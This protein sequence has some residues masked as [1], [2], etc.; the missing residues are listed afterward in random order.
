MNQKIKILIA[1]DHAVVRAGLTTLLGTEDDIEVV[2]QAKNGNE[3][4]S[5]T[6]ESRRT[7][8]TRRRKSTGDIPRQRYSS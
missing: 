2:A 1:D 5:K 7:A 3:A 6:L 4:I 8:R